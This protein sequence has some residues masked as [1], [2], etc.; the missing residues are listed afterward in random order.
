M[1]K[2]LMTVVLFALVGMSYGCPKNASKPNNES[3]PPIVS[4]PKKLTS[5][6]Q[7]QRRTPVPQIP[8]EDIKTREA[9]DDAIIQIGTD[10]KEA[11]A[12]RNREDTINRI[13]N[14]CF[15]IEIS[16]AAL[17]VI[18]A[19]LV[20][21]FTK[22]IKLALTIIAFGAMIVVGA[23]CVGWVLAHMGMIGLIA[24]VIVASI[25]GWKIWEHI[26]EIKEFGKISSSKIK[27]VTDVTKELADAK[28]LNSERYSKILA[29]FKK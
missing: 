1:K 10:D 28:I 14:W 26:D 4:E 24:G 6:E 16:A 7:L 20:I 9:E 5:I 13:K 23:Y 2:F 11:I 19:G 18:G 17:A 29:K 22:S 15:W 21:Y 27:D 8:K 3:K 12:K 25:F